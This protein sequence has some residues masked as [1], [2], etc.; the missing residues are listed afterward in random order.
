M[1]QAIQQYNKKRQA[2]GR[3]P[4]KVGIGLNTGQLMLGIIGDPKR[5]DS[6]VISDAVNTAS[7][8]EGLTKFF[9][10][11]IILSESTLSE[12][13]EPKSYHTRYLG[14]VQ[15]KGKQQALKIYECFDGDTPAEK[16]L[17][18]TTAKDF[19]LGVFYYL[20]KTFIKSVTAFKAVLAQNPKD[21]TAKLFLD[22]AEKL[23]VADVPEDW[24]GV[25]MMG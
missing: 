2:K 17:K 20:D 14:L 8:M 12:L 22:R 3:L 24:T 11:S 23:A 5:Y 16:S 1:Q 9:G 19:E 10:T 13:T 18:L 7:R 4:I 21:K 6:S 15:V 25:E